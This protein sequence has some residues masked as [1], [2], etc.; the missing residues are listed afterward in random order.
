M[1][2]SDGEGAASSQ[3]RTASSLGLSDWYEN[4]TEAKACPWIWMGRRYRLLKAPKGF[5]EAR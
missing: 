4:S 5:S 2:S 3:S 1:A